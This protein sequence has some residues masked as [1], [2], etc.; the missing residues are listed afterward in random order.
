MKHVVYSCKN[1]RDKN[2]VSVCLTLFHLY[3]EWYTEKTSDKLKWLLTMTVGMAAN[4]NTMLI[5][6]MLASKNDGFLM[7]FA[8]MRFFFNIQELNLHKR[9]ECGRESVF[10]SCI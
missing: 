7:I 4:S 6:A 1:K 8:L 10:N 3:C 9:Q 5:S 2:Y